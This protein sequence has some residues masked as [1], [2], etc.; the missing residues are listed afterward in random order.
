LHERYVAPART[1][2]TLGS[3]GAIAAPHRA[4]NSSQSVD[5]AL[6]YGAAGG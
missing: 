2:V 4:V 3:V 5:N 1:S 6:A